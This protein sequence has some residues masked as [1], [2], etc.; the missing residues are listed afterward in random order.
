MR[1]Y[2]VVP[3]KTKI[4]IFQMKPSIGLIFGHGSWHILAKNILSQILLQKPKIPKKINSPQTHF[5]LGGG[6]LVFRRF[7]LIII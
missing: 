3:G 2:K 5:F 4:L 6:A 7:I 1:F